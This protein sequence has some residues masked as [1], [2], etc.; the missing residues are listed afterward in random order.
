ML[1]FFFGVLN[2]LFVITAYHAYAMDN[3][4]EWEIALDEGA[5][6]YKIFTESSYGKLQNEGFS[7]SE[8]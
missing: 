1:K 8:I 6:L 5:F 4:P 2:I 7:P 3:K